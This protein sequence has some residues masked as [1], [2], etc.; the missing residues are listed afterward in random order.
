[1]CQSPG[2]ARSLTHTAIALLKRSEAAV[3]A[4][5]ARMRRRRGIPGFDSRSAAS[6]L[7]RPDAPLRPAR[8]LRALTDVPLRRP[9]PFVDHHLTGGV[10]RM[11]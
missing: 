10:R 8:G 7:L 9:A 4:V 1:M 5:F 3:R 2:G 6:D 11:R